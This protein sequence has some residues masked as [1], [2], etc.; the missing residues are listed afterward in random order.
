MGASGEKV[1]SNPSDSPFILPSLLK[2]NSQTLIKD[3]S[4]CG[5]MNSFSF[6]RGFTCLIP[7]A[8][9]P[10]DLWAGHISV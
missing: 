4:Y 1:G 9:C 6:R 3:D 8:S 10:F 5:G 2:V 7:F